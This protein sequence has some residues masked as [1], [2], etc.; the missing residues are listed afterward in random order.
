MFKDIQKRIAI[1]L[2]FCIGS[3]LGIAYLAK[4]LKGLWRNI[5]SLI[6]AVMG[7]GFLI[8]YFGGL[9]KTGRE[10]GGKLIWWN[11]LRPIHGLLYLT[12]SALLYY[13]HSCWSSQVIVIDTMIGL[14]AFLTYH[15]REGNIKLF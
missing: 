8:I 14:S 4:K 3:R 6:I 10:T 7:A 11:H 9:R 1:F 13:G 12:A 5:L 2:I 15:L